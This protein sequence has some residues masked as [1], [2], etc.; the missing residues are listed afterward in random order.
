MNFCGYIRHVTTFNWMLTI[1][2]CLVVGLALGLDLVSACAHISVLVRIVM[3]TLLLHWRL[4]SPKNLVH[5]QRRRAFESRPSAVLLGKRWW[6]GSIPLPGS[7]ACTQT[8][9]GAQGWWPWTRCTESSAADGE[10]VDAVTLLSAHHQL[11]GGV[12]DTCAESSTNSHLAN[13]LLMLWICLLQS[14]IWSRADFSLACRTCCY[15]G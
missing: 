7:W 9:P 10:L 2:C 6:R 15:S 11:N 14:W 5:V 12:L 13:S 4:L 1:V 8:T 3:V